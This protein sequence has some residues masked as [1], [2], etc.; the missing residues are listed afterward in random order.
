MPSKYSI[1]PPIGYGRNVD[2]VKME[3]PVSNLQ[4]PGIL[5]QHQTTVLPEYQEDEL[6]RYLPQYKYLPDEPIVLRKEEE[7]S[8]LQSVHRN[9]SGMEFMRLKEIYTELTGYDRHLTGYVTYQDL[10]FTFL[11]NQASIFVFYRYMVQ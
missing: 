8:L 7:L 1:V 9:L 11:R 3:R 10:S 4:G 6:Y 2:G 5:S